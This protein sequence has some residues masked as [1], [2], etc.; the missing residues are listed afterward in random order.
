MLLSMKRCLTLVSLLFL[1]FLAA[2]Q[3][4]G[5]G[6]DT[7]SVR[8]YQLLMQVR[9]HEITSICMMDIQ[10]DSSVLGTVVNEFGV[11]AFD[12]TYANG[13]AK[14]FNVVGPLNKW[15][16]KRVLKG[17]FSF[18]LANIGLGKDVVKKKRR[19]SF[20]PNGDVS[21]SNERFKIQYTFTPIKVKGE[22]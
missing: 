2:C 17:D 13:K 16:I 11:K 4:E 22:E 18:I 15:Y 21:V 10:A 6:Q 8:E 5:I 14:V 19:L 3:A 1:F 7:A 20:L 12:F 9:G